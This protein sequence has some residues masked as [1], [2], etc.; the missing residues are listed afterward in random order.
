MASRRLC[1]NWANKNR[2]VSETQLPRHHAHAQSL[3]GET[4]GGFNDNVNI[5]SYYIISYLF[6]WQWSFFV[7]RRCTHSILWMSCFSMGLHTT[8]LCS[9]I[10][11]TNMQNAVISRLGS[12]DW[13]QRI[14]SFARSEALVT[15]SISGQF[16]VRG[17]E[18]P[19]AYVHA[20]FEM[21][22]VA[23]SVCEILRGSQNFE[24]GSRTPGHAHLGAN[25]WSG[26]KN[27]PRP[28][29]V[30]YLKGV[31]LSVCEILA[32]FAALH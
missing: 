11:I 27:C 31:A 20:K 19:T 10:G 28:M 30:P 21:K 16:V 22:I 15:S 23:F 18:L 2:W 24:I 6:D 14:I 1:C 25:L 29:C 7:K 17:Q 9:S 5:I 13:K 12:W 3:Q 32:H 26:S 4:I 8:E